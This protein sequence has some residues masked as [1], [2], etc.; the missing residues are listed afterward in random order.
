MNYAASIVVLLWRSLALLTLVSQD[1]LMGTAEYPDFQQHYTAVTMLIASW[2][3]TFGRITP[4]A[5]SSLGGLPAITRR[6]VLFMA[7][8]GDLAILL[9]DQ[10]LR[11]LGE[12]LAESSPLPAHDSLRATLRSAK[13]YCQ[14]QRFVSAV[15][16]SH[17]AATNIGVSSTISQGGM[18]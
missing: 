6:C 17:L 12:R 15:H 16:L 18:G 11:E 5:T 4:E 3:A 13:A 8:D 7:T 1:L 9:F 2:R 10:L 14:E